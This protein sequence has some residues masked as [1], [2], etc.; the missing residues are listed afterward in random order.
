MNKRLAFFPL[1][2]R[3]SMF[4]DPIY[5]YRIF[6]RVMEVK[7]ESEIIYETEGFLKGQWTV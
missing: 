6:G 3:I 5:V 1:S 4:I 7:E 2:K